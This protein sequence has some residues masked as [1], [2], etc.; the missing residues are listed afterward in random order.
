MAN[1]FKF[2]PGVGSAMGGIISSATAVALTT[3]LGEAYII[4]MEMICKGEM[5]IDELSKEKG[6]KEVTE[7]F[8]KQLKVIRNK[9]R[10][11]Q[12]KFPWKRSH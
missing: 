7:I 11:L 1:L 5:S 10:K 3:A 6:K 9:N 4:I 2:I 8:T 12:I